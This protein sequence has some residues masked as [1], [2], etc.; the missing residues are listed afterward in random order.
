[1]AFLKYKY[2]SLCAAS[3]FLIGACT[4]VVIPYRGNIPSDARHTAKSRHN[5]V[6]AMQPDNVFLSRFDTGHGSRHQAHYFSLSAAGQNFHGEYFQSLSPGKHKTII[7]LPIFG[8]SEIPSASIA[9]HLF[10]W[11]TNVLLLHD[12]GDLFDWE[13]LATIEKERDF[14]VSV[15]D[16]VKKFE[17]AVEGTKKIVSWFVQKP[18][19]DPDRIG[20]VGLSLGAM[21][22]VAAAGVDDRISAVALVMGGARFDEIFARSNA[23]FIRRVRKNAFIKFAIS[24]EEF[25]RKI[26]QAAHSIEPEIWAK[27]LNPSQVIFFEA[28]Y[29]G[30]LPKSSRLALYRALGSPEA[31]V[32]YHNHK[33]SFISATVAGLNYTP[34]KIRSFFKEKL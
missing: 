13:F 20:I 26:R 16:T 24:P 5:L 8:S 9:A 6:Y 19:V 7:V 29:D 2:A 3:F 31:V 32:F 28:A 15:A 4:S 22:A 34:W 10:D 11:D 18:D 14:F 25:S 21:V 33:T 27:N 1:M 12:P 30:F 17:N 23:E